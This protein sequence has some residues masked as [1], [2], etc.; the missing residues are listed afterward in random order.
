[1]KRIITFLHQAME[2]IMVTCKVMNSFCEDIRKKI[3]CNLLRFVSVQFR[4][5]KLIKLNLCDVH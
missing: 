2:N 1:M 5:R 4:L 3:L